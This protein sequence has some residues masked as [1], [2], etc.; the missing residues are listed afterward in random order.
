MTEQSRAE[1]RFFQ[2]LTHG[3]RADRIHQTQDD[4]FVSEQLQGPVTSPAR[5]VGTGQLN[6]LLFHVPFDLDLVRTCRLRPVIDR[7]LQSFN[8]KSFADASNGFQTGAERSD[9]FIVGVVFSPHTISQQ[10]NAGV[11]Q[12]ATGR[13]PSGNEL[14]QGRA[15][16]RNQRDVL[17][18]R[19]WD[20]RLCSLRES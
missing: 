1:C 12:F 9:N 14:F 6:Q 16:L 5:R 10:Q 3:L 18:Q 4:H 2:R 13:H 11:G 8:D 19:E 17:V 15:F 20:K 7:R